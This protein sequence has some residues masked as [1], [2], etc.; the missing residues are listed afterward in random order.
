MKTITIN[1][2]ALRITEGEQ[3][4]LQD[5]KYWG[6]ER[7]RSDMWEGGARGGYSINPNYRDNMK[8][9]GIREV[10]K[11][12]FYNRHSKREAAFFKRHPR[13]ETVIVGDPKRI[14]LILKKLQEIA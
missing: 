6:F 14:N 13:C 1:R 11:N 2:K 8:K 10:Y 5:F 12:T 9:L 3:R 4:G 7:K